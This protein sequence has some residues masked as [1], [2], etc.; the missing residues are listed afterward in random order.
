MSNPSKGMVQFQGKT[1]RVAKVSR[2]RYEVIRLLDDRRIGTFESTPRLRVEP[3]GVEPAFLHEL[4][5]TALKQAK[6][7]WASHRAVEPTRAPTAPAAR[8]SQPTSSRPHP[9]SPSRKAFA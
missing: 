2:G 1:Y 6:V 8:A 3:E 9:K 5:L 4:A 7:S